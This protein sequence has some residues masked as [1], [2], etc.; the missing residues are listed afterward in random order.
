MTESNSSPS[1]SPLPAQSGWRRRLNAFYA[2]VKSLQGDPHYV[3]MGMAS[4][5]FVAVTPTIPFHTVLAL[6]F[7]FV[8]KGSKP[9]AAIGAWFCNPLTIGPFY[10][11]SYQLGMLMLGREISIDLEVISFQDLLAMG[12]DVALA[13]V[14][15]GALL[16]IVPAIA[17]YFLTLHMFRK[18]RARRKQAHQTGVD[19]EQDRSG[20][21]DPLQG[22]ATTKTQKP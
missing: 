8:L 10:L 7:A 17:A 11:G 19:D 9:A 21:D 16:G 14:V 18:I 1:P 4:G 12:A 6:A 20:K 13:M 5:V 2:R 22:T 15:G 3:A